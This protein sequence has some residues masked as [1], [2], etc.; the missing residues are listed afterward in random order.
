MAEP[1]RKSRP[2]RTSALPNPEEQAP[3]PDPM[4]DRPDSMDDVVSA[5]P[6]ADEIA[7]RAYERYQSRGGEDGHD[8]DDW[9][10]AERELREGPRHDEP[11]ARAE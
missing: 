1:G 7:A 4:G 2:F 3:R 11:S 10:E 8:I 9:L 5:S 6:S